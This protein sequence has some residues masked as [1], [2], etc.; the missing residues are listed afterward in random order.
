MSRLPEN[1]ALGT[2]ARFV[3]SP[4]LM[5]VTVCGFASLSLSMTGLVA[6]IVHLIA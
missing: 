3:T 2:T 1:A 6:M 5:I 4:I